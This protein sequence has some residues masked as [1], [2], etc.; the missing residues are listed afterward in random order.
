MF[1]WNT[2]DEIVDANLRALEH[3]SSWSI[4]SDER[5]TDMF[6][7]G[8][9]GV[10]EMLPKDVKKHFKFPNLF[11]AGAHYSLGST[12]R[13]NLI[14]SIVEAIRLGLVSVADDATLTR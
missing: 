3:F 13:R 5:L 4:D 10:Q 12:Y 7:N 2:G 9:I 14:G 11:V 8:V 1:N 6:L